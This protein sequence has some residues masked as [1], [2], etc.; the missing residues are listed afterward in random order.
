MELRC[1]PWRYSSSHRFHDQYGQNITKGGDRGDPWMDGLVGVLLLNNRLYLST[2]TS[3]TFL[4]FSSLL[5]LSSLL[6]LLILRRFYPTSMSAYHSSQP[7]NEDVWI[8]ECTHLLPPKSVSVILLAAP[9][10]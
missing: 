3:A 1:G 8:L 9:V 2:S 6:F 10:T 4:L 5:I 7:K